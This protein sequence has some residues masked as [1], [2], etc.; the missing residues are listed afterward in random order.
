V[1]TAPPEDVAP[2]RIVAIDGP[3]GA[4]KSTVARALARHLGWRYL[5]T[6]AMYRAVTWAVVARG[7]S[8]GDATALTELA[9]DVALD[10]GTD[11]DD[12]YVRV[13]DEDVGAAIRSHAVE[14]AVSAISAV[15]GVRAE[16]VARQRRIAD[17]GD[18]IVEGRDIGTAVL[19]RATLKVFLTAADD[20]RADRRGRD[21]AALRASGRAASTATVDLR[22][23]R[24]E[25][26][27]RDRADSTRQADP[28]RPADDAIVLDSSTMG[29]D[30][31]V[32][33]ILALIAA[34]P[35]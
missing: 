27:R 25:L 21:E 13:E 17:A 29:I 15:A 9:H 5:D 7:V 12:A 14:R 31:V 1:S 19:P 32:A 28:L 23:T 8:P 26:A 33:R 34:V 24:T 2:P 10:L 22:R 30:A 3:S 18:I 11:P 20:V 4:G 16:L 35:R 6:G